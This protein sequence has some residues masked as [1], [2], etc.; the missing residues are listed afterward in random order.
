MDKVI[1]TSLRVNKNQRKFAP[2]LKKVKKNRNKKLESSSK[3]KVTE[4][5]VKNITDNKSNIIKNNVDGDVDVKQINVAKKGTSQLISKNPVTIKKLDTLKSSKFFHLN[6]SFISPEKSTSNSRLKLLAELEDKQS[7]LSDSAHSSNSNSNSKN[8]SSISYDTI[9]QVPV[10]PVKIVTS[11]NIASVISNDN[12]NINDTLTPVFLNSTPKG[13]HNKVSNYKR[14]D[15]KKIQSLSSR[16]TLINNNKIVNLSFSGDNNLDIQETILTNS[17]SCSVSDDEITLVKID[18]SQSTIISDDNNSIVTLNQDGEEDSSNRK[19]KN[20]NDFPIQ[21]LKRKD[22]KNQPI[23]IP[24]RTLTYRSSSPI[25]W[26]PRKTKFNDHFFLSNNNNDKSSSSSSSLHDSM[27]NYSKILSKQNVSH[28]K[29]KS[30]SK[31]DVNDDSDHKDEDRISPFLQKRHA[32]STDKI[33]LNKSSLLKRKISTLRDDI[34]NSKLNNLDDTDDTLEKKTSTLIESKE[35]NE[36]NETETTEN[37]DATIIVSDVKYT[38]KNDNN[39]NDNNNNNKNDDDNNNHEKIKSNKIGNL[40]NSKKILKN[41]HR[42]NVKSYIDGDDDDKK[43]ESIDFSKRTLADII[44]NYHGKEQS[45]SQK[46]RYK[47]AVQK[48]KATLRKKRLIQMGII[49]PDLENESLSIKP[50]TQ[51]TI[52]RKLA[53]NVAAVQMRVVNGVAVIDNTSICINHMDT[54]NE[55]PITLKDNQ[56]TPITS[57][58]FKKNSNRSKKWKKDETDLFFQC[59]SICGTD[60]GMMSVIMPHRNRKQLINKYHRESR[61]NPE[62]IR[63]AFEK[64]RILDNKD[65]NAII[66]KIKNKQFKNVLNTANE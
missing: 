23:P 8:S 15:I 39:N 25:V 9:N 57:L 1:V 38:N 5:K 31:D 27:F 3:S 13:S 28:R 51:T 35:I 42:K 52:E 18:N 53:D 29:R 11:S 60:F 34:F 33:S 43:E 62:R 66:E 50:Q 24:I 45:S 64:R 44:D 61:L 54:T 14:N 7:N 16:S 49:D 41:L 22:R 30:G 59:I 55:L 4:N 26:T 32:L 10:I 65:L 2:S 12:H 63:K 58:S 40:K 21:N 47:L 56:E 6:N 36:I 19:E 37:E 48:R 46:E 17:N 20:L